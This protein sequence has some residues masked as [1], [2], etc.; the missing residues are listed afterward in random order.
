MAE[1]HIVELVKTNVPHANALIAR[2]Y[3][4]MLVDTEAE[5]L[6]LKSGNWMA[7]RFVVVVLG[8]PEGVEHVD[9]RA[10]LAEDREA[11]RQQP[12]EQQEEAEAIPTLG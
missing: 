10:A 3:R 7:H 11:A 8:R 5:P 12:Q 6:Q 1:T 9:H 4:V 2:G